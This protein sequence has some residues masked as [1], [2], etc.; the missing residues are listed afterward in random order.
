M[1]FTVRPLTP[2]FRPY[3]ET[4]IAPHGASS[5]RRTMHHAFKRKAAS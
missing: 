2:D 4:L 5:E 3:L 1:I